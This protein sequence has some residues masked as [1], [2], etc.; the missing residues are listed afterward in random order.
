MQS[1]IFFLNPNIY[2]DHSTSEPSSSMNLLFLKSVTPVVV[3]VLQ[4]P[5]S[6]SVTITNQTET[7]LYLYINISLFYVFTFSLYR[8]LP[9]ELGVIEILTNIET[10]H[11]GLVS[12][13]CK[14]TINILVKNSIEILE[15]QIM[16]IL[17]DLSGHM[18]PK[19]TNFLLEATPHDRSSTPVKLLR[20]LD[21]NL[22]FLKN[23][24]VPENFD[25]VLSSVWTASSLSLA[26]IIEQSIADRQDVK[27]FS[28]LHHVFA[29]LLNFF[30]G[31]EIPE[32]NSSLVDIKRTL[33]LLQLYSASPND[34]ILNY[35][36][37][38]FKHQLEQQHP[39]GDRTSVYP[40]GSITVRAIG[41]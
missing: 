33:K 41:K 14:K 13:A 18:A 40:F 26:K 1:G 27:Y 35:Y 34:L 8:P 3:V 4:F 25:R 30:Y 23:W 7:K 20:F 37:E 19:I 32:Q 28:H 6:K 22:I 29:V 10:I 11:G 16:E 21:T 31:G 5:T 24:L 15:N 9:E 39:N 12:D 36:S 2:L 38:R 17:E